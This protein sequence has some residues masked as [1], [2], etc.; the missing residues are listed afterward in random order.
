MIF[1]TRPM[2]E[3]LKKRDPTKLKAPERLYVAVTRARFSVAFVVGDLADLGVKTMAGS[4][5]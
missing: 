3:Y 4:G 1:P 2:V 5:G